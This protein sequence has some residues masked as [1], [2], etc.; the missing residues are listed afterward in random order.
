M[1]Y[2]VRDVV[3]LR[4]FVYLRSRDVPLQRI[5]KAVASLR[6]PGEAGHLSEYPLVAVGRD[7]AWRISNGE[8]VDLTNSPGQA[9]LA[10]MVDIVAPFVNMRSQSVV[11]LRRPSRGISG[12][13]RG[14]WRIPGPG[15]IRVPYDLVAS[16]LDD[17]LVPAAITDI[18]PSVSVEAVYDAAE[19]AQYVESFD[20][21][22]AVA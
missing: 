14:S 17:G 8:A 2:S 22:R 12:D 18:Y 11:D 21:L 13:T 9:V 5:R 19:F 7:V 4:T 20:R 15:G 1:A 10:R 6:K 3:A 16:L